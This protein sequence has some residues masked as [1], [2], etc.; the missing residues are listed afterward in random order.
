MLASQA[1]LISR[2]QSGMSHSQ[3]SS[4]LWRQDQVQDSGLSVLM[5][6]NAGSSLWLSSYQPTMRNSKY[7]FFITSSLLITCILIRCIMSLIR[8]VKS[9]WPCP[10]C[11]VP[12]DELSDTS[13]TYARRTSQQS[14]AVVIA[15]R[16]KETAEEK[17]V[18][19]K[20]YGLRDV[21]VRLLPRT[22][23]GYSANTLQNAFWLL[24]TLTDVHRA[25]SWDRLHSHHGGLWSDHFFVELQ[26]FIT[27]LGRDSVAQIDKMYVHPFYCYSNCLSLSNITD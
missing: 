12:R 24:L 2:I 14:Q 6:Y 25:L 27:G 20:E 26:A 21:T 1:G 19:L 7:V 11:L 4:L 17:E 23:L 10:I 15:A 5:M 18:V 13:K 8:G 16:K 9:L 3:R 22:T